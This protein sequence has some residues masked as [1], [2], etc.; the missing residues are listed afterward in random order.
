MTE[1]LPR[2]L[3]VDDERPILRFLSAS[4]SGRYSVSEAA[5]G[6]DAIQAVA[7][8]QPDLIILDLGLPD[9]EYLS[10]GGF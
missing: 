6:E 5:T 2:I 10:R 3:V 7:R 1:S 9:I 4:L 8:E